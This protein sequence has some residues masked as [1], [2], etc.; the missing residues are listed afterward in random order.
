MKNIIYH[1]ADLDG[2]CSAAIVK[3]FLLAQGTKDEEIRM[4]GWDYGQPSPIQVD[5]DIYIVD[6]CLP[7]ND[8]I[9]LRSYNANV[10]WIDHHKSAI[11]DSMGKWDWLPG[12]RRVGDSAAK[13]CWEFFYPDV[14]LPTVV[15]WVDR[16]DVWKK[17]SES[18]YNDWKSVMEIQ[19]GMRAELKD[20][21]D[22]DAFYLWNESF[23]FLKTSI[24][25]KGTAI[26]KFIEDQNVIIS[27]RA[28]VLD[29]EGLQFCAVNHEGN[30]ETVKSVVKPEHDAIMLF[31]FDGQLGKWKFSLYENEL[32]PKKIDLSVIAKKLGGGGHAGACG[33]ECDQIPFDY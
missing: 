33:F 9:A 24:I 8:M 10:V 21:K 4:L 18:G 17:T 25:N 23:T 32:N 26:Y 16:F 6:I 11:Q 28:F 27:K 3:K 20:P 31:R 15:Y 22:P 30:S 7:E 12:L 5:G 14:P 29:F 2:F 1:N 19:W 13:L